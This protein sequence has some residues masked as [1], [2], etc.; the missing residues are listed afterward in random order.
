MP[1]QIRLQDTITD[2]NARPES[3]PG[4]G[5]FGAMAHSGM[6]RAA[7][8]VEDTISRHSILDTAFDIVPVSGRSVYAE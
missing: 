6:L 1:L 7:S 8:Y 5:V 3:V 4:S 2:L